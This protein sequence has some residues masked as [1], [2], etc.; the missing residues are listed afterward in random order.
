MGNKRE[1]PYNLLR[2]FLSTLVAGYL[3][4]WTIYFFCTLVLIIK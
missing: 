1:V 3:A 4:D 2:G